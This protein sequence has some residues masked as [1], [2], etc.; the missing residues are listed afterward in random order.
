MMGELFWAMM[1]GA[2]DGRVGR[3]LGIPVV[4]LGCAA[5]GAAGLVGFG[6]GAGSRETEIDSF[7]GVLAGDLGHIRN[8]RAWQIKERIKKRD[9]E[10]LLKLATEVIVSH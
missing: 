7:R 9:K 8:T 5:S 4:G 1:T 3:S 6:S 10:E 2:R